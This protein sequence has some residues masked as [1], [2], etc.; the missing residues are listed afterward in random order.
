MKLLRFGDPDE[1]LPA[2]F[3]KVDLSHFNS[4]SSSR[5]GRFAFEVCR[6]F[7]SCG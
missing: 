2:A 1:E 7:S 3:D 5:L 4:A 6:R